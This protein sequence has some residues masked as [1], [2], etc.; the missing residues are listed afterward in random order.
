MSIL[1]FPGC[2]TQSKLTTLPQLPL[3]KLPLKLM[4]HVETI[5]N[6]LLTFYVYL[7]QRPSQRYRVSSLTTDETNQLNEMEDVEV[8]DVFYKSK[9]YNRLSQDAKTKLFLLRKQRG[10]DSSKSRRGSNKRK[11]D[12]SDS[13]SNSK[14]KNPS[15]NAI[16]KLNNALLLLKLKRHQAMNRTQATH[17]R[18]MGRMERMERM[19]KMERKR[20]RKYVLTNVLLPMM[21]IVNEG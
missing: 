21:K 15:R 10:D 7:L 8:E 1:V 5:S 12:R 6:L 11:R 19:E 20:E 17:Q 2:L 18:R 4:Q 3:P 13:S 16:K 14:E 9:D